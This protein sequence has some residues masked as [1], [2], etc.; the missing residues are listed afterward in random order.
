M[1]TTINLLNKLI[2]EAQ[3]ILKT[4]TKTQTIITALEDIIRR[5]NSKK[6]L[7]LRGSLKEDFDYKEFRR[8]R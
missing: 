2:D 5:K 4:K 6:I 1:R 8:K 3:K 7:A